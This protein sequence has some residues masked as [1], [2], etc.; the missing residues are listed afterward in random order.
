ME[1]LPPPT[2]AEVSTTASGHGLRAAGTVCGV[3]GIAFLVAGVISGL[4]TRAYSD[5]VESDQVFNRSKADRGALYEKLQWTAY[6][7]GAGLAVTGA[8]LYWSG[9]SKS[10]SPSA[11]VMPVSGG[12]A[13]FATGK[14]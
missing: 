3:T 10:T 4:E 1:I 12:A 13:L 5:S 2:A 9:G 6:G 8:L 11:V 7:V 14:F